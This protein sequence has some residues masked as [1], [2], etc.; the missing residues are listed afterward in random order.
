MSVAEPS[1]A[2]NAGTTK[3][4]EEFDL[5]FRASLRSQLALWLIGFYHHSSSPSPIPWLG[6]LSLCVRA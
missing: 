1:D 5:D 3:Q 2:V 4:T 6:W